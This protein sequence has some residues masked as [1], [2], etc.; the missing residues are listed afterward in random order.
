MQEL[1]LEEINKSETSNANKKKRKNRNKKRKVKNPIN[2]GEKG[3]ENENESNKLKSDIIIINNNNTI[4]TPPPSS[5]SLQPSTSPLTNSTSKTS[6]INKKNHS[7]KL[8]QYTDKSINISNTTS[9]PSPPPVPPHE[10]STS[11]DFED[12]TSDSEVE[13][14]KALLQTIHQQR[15]SKKIEVKNTGQS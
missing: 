15:P 11:A 12:D 9:L 1:L 8:Q 4:Q 6:I 5:K 2:E 13:S 7:N 10:K 3:N 14:F